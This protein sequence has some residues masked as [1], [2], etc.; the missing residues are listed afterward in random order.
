VKQKPQPPETA[1]L[2][3]DAELFM[4]ELFSFDVN[5]ST[6]VQAL[7]KISELQKKFKK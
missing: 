7:L 5:S 1:E 2:F 6:P 3:T 4:D